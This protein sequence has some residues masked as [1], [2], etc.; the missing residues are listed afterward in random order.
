LPASNDRESGKNVKYAAIL[1]I[2]AK[3]AMSFKLS[4]LRHTAYRERPGMA[5]CGD[6]QFVIIFDPAETT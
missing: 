2:F 4:S 1:M 6:R 3:I 5:V